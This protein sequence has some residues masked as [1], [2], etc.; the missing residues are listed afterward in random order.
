MFLAFSEMSSAVAQEGS[1][2]NTVCFVPDTE[3]QLDP[4]VFIRV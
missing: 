3:A 1:S 4:S 2:T